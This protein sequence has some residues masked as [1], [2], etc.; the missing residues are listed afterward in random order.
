MVTQET[1]QKLSRAAKGRI[2]S[3]SHKQKIGRANR[4]RHF[5]QEIRKKMS[6]SAKLRWRNPEYRRASILAQKGK[7]LSELHRRNISCG[8]RG[9]IFSKEHREKISIGA[10][11]RSQSP[12]FKKTFLLRMSRRHPRTKIE[13]R[14]LA[15]L[16]EKSVKYISQ[17]AIM[18]IPRHVFDFI[19]AT[20]RIAIEVDGCYWHVCPEHY[21][22]TGLTNPREKRRALQPIRDHSYM[23]LAKKQGW[24]VIRLWEH[25]IEAGNFS[26]LD[27]VLSGS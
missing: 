21:P 16:I 4:G 18:G 25:E 8:L 5:S 10:K 11:R 19:I 20:Q 17:E 6:F 26:R 12:E 15:W 27:V 2:L 7:P 24:T 14:V 3:E 1:R 23:E 13:V 22:L 9:R